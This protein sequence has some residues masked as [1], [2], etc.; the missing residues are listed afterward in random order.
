MN[1]Q[2]IIKKKILV[3]FLLS[4]VFAAL[5][6][7]EL[8]GIGPDRIQYENYFNKITIY[9]FNSRYESGFE[10]FNIFTGHVSINF[11]RRRINKVMN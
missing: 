3:V 2:F 8:F 1:N 6:S 9:D 10:Y 5:S 4:I 7:L 11:F